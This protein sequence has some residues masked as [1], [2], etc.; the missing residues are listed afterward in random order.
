[1]R[2]NVIASEPFAQFP[3]PP[4]R[5]VTETSER[6][7][8]LS[9]CRRFRVVQS[10]CR[11]G[12]SKGPQAMPLSWRVE[13]FE[14]ADQLRPWGGWRILSSHSLPLDAFQ[15]AEALIKAGKEAPRR[16]GC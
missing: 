10:R 2:S 3:S 1:M 12:P 16:L 6:W 15:A 9:R 14:P 5:Q 8:W 7:I 11:Y 13:R 4:S